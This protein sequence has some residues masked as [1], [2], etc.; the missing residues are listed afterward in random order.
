MSPV[1][2]LPRTRLEPDDRRRQILEAARTLYAER[3]YDRVS[4]AELARAAGVTRGLLH[5]YFGSKRDIFLA[6]MRDSVLMPESELPDLLHLPLTERVRVTMDWILEAAQT[7]GQ[8]WV[9]ASGAAELHGDS[10]AQAVVDEAD[11]RAARLVLDAVGMPDDAHQRA[12]L[13]A[14]AAYVKALCREWLQR[15]TLGRD[16]V[17]DLL[18]VH[19]TTVL[20]AP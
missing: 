11:D 2:T 12:R 6:V 15:G 20:E 9:V 4:M 7:Y 3:A 10:D 19:V 18:T 13:R 1:S 5:H 17:L 14:S 8:A 16:E